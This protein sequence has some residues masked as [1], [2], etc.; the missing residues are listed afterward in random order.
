[1]ALVKKGKAVGFFPPYYSKERTKWAKF[2]EP[3][4]AEKSSVYAL[5]KTLKGKKRFPEDFY[6]MTVCLNKGFTLLTGGERMKV[7]I[8]HGDLNL[9]YGKNNRACL[10][11]VYRG[12]ADFYVNDQLIDISEFSEIQRGLSATENFGHIGF[13]LKE[14]KYPYLNDFETKFNKVI[15][16]MK[17]SGEIDQI[18]KNYES[19]K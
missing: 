7:A 6:G 17:K 12:L 8:E 19:G 2:S 18:L 3:I 15:I 13:T 9:V 16:E 14:K 11:R 10:G 4:L 1:M 5:S